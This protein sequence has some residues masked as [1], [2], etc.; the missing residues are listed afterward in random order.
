MRTNYR[1]ALQTFMIIT[2][3]IITLVF[4]L[5]LINDDALINT[6]TST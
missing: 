2:N 1:F 6:R 5:F 4:N 3:L